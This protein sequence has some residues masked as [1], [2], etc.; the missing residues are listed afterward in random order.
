[1]TGSDG[2]GQL[3]P[4]RNCTD[5]TVVGNVDLWLGDSQ[6]GTGAFSEWASTGCGTPWLIYCVGIGIHRPLQPERASGRIAFTSTSLF[7]AKA[8]LAA[9]DSL[10]SN[11]ARAASLPGSYK[12]LLALNG[13]SAVSRLNLAGPPWVRT[14]GVPVV[15][16][17]Q[18][19]AVKK[20][21]ASIGVSATQVH[22]AKFALVWAGATS[23]GEPGTAESTC[24]AW[25][26]DAGAL[27]VVGFAQSTNPSA[28]FGTSTDWCLVP[29]HLYCLQE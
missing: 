27:G 3:A 23:P 11:E 8:G 20:L 19:L 17:A 2:T 29:L 5:W 28:S 18:D 24:A 7:E 4:G 15:A 14:D 10:C 25:S 6:G 12:A 16:K 21:L 1:M 22:H 26:S 13:A 9:A